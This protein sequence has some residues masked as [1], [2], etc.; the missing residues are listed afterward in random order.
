MRAIESV[1]AGGKASDFETQ[2]VDF[3]EEMGSRERDGSV[4]QIGPRS[5][6]VASTLAKEAAC[7]A[8]T[9]DGG[10][11]IVGVADNKS[12]EDAFI[13]TQSDAEWLKQ[14]IL[15]LTQPNL[16]VEIEEI[17]VLGKR[18]LL[19]NIPDAIREIHA[20]GKLQ[21]RV[22]SS[23][24]ELTGEQALR[25]LESR[26]NFDWSAQKSGKRLSQSVVEALESARIHFKDAK[27]TAPES[28]RELASR[29][30]VLCD[31][32][33]DPELT[34]AGALLLC[35]YEP[36]IEQMH[37]M[38]TDA[39]GVASRH[40]VRGPAPLLPLFDDVMRLLLT[41]A[42]PSKSE[43]VGTQ[44]RD[45]R[46]IPELAI[47]ESIVNA[48]MH[49]DYRISSAVVVAL[50]TGSPSNVF[51]VIS[52][53]GLLPGIFTTNMIST[54]SRLRNPNLA[55]A[56]RTLGL[57]EKEG[58]GI[59]TIYREM[60]KEGHPQPE[61][62][63]QDG[64]LMVRLSGG[65]P[66]T[67]VLEFF[68]ALSLKDKYL[69]EN[70]R[71]IM[72]I[73][74]LLTKPTIRPESLSVIAQ[75]SREDALHVLEQ[76]EEVSSIERLL[77]GSLTFR[78]SPGSRTQLTELLQYSLR[79]TLEEQA[80]LVVSYLDSHPD[81]GREEVRTMLNVKEVRATTVL[82]EMVRRELLDYVGPTRGRNVR[83][84]KK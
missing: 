21:T 6:P 58:I 29:L 35:E 11:L 17:D 71:A 9:E 83:Y 13:G 69:P 75:C 19:I 5:E 39:E 1:K 67:R 48:I 61:I 44:R 72:A 64:S 62:T 30:G 14:R 7:M 37:L 82:K 18:L 10:V 63:E 25:F 59:D 73:R 28:N 22:G 84:K 42:F 56:L 16:V 46:P 26:R 76:M 24:V 8:N 55:D 3:K 27:G 38:I 36:A 20:N 31:N 33:D 32:E 12:G 49:R 60:M 34:R 68:S 81:I 66:D 65:P 50:A 54:P 43:F 51:K 79:S 70:V 52:P 78:L 74:Y 80:E 23:C 57:A 40:N 45:L 41:E 4:S 15:A 47:R 2:T 53:G 77:N